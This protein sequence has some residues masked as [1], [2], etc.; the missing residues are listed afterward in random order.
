MW[1]GRDSK[2]RVEG[3]ESKLADWD[4]SQSTHRPKRFSVPYFSGVELESSKLS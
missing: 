2:G 3:R 1:Y 4:A